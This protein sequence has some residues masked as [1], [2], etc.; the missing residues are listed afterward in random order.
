MEMTQMGRIWQH[1]SM[2]H[3]VDALRVDQKLSNVT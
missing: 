2:W 1:L 3:I